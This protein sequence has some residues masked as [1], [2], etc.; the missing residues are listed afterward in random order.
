M[1]LSTLGQDMA[2]DEIR[3]VALTTAVLKG[4]E[5]LIGEKS[6]LR[7]Q[8]KIPLAKRRQGVVPRDITERTL[9]DILR[10]PKKDAFLCH[11]AN[12]LAQL[13]AVLQYA[14]RISVL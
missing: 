2:N 1:R 6:T 11:F 13:F 4:L 3:V 8:A 9:C 5:D 14:K 7:K 12:Y 10:A